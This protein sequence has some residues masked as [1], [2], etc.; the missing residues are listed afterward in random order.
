MIY[1]NVVLSVNN[2]TDVATVLA[3]L[4]E[5]AG[6]SRAEPGCERFEVYQ[7]NEHPHIFF[8]IERWANEQALANHKEATAVQTIYF[9]KVLPLVER[10]P[11]PSTLVTG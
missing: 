6:L 2:P 10:T 3:L 7:S 1:Q 9:P 11:H 4:T 5:H 8:L